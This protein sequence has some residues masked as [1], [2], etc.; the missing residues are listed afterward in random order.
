MTVS[1][2]SVS[3]YFISICGVVNLLEQ[4]SS[5]AVQRGI[6]SVAQNMGIAK[7]KKLWYVTSSGCFLM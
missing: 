3:L 2:L 4:K 6:L 5:V 1:S 7:S